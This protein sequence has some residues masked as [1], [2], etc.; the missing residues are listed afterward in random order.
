MFVIT[1]TFA[2]VAPVTPV[3]EP[4][5]VDGVP[6]TFPTVTAAADFVEAE[7]APFLADGD[8]VVIAAA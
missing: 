5:A 4:V 2:T 1:V 3:A 8:L 6:V 7:L